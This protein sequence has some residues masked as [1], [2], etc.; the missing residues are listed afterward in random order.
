MGVNTRNSIVTSGLVLQLDAA[1]MKSYISGS[2]TLTDLSGRNNS[3]SLNNT[4]YGANFGGNIVFK[5]STTSFGTIANTGGSLTFGTGDFSI[6]C[7]FN[8]NGASQIAASIL[9]GLGS[10]GDATNWQFGFGSTNRLS[11]YYNNAVFV[12][13]TYNPTT[14]GPTNAVVTRSGGLVRIYIN[15]IFNVSSAD[16]GGNNFSDTS[17]L[18]LGQ[19]RGGTVAYNGSISTVRLYNKALSAGEVAQNYN[20]LKARFG[21]S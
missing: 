13:S 3:G 12:P 16:G 18:K 9:V 1:N 4:G 21:L 2:T 6:E 8:T 14:P 20:A 11:F 5:N 19:N 10:A 17:E 15:G 7:W